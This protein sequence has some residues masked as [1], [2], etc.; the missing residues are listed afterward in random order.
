M[1]H[2]ANGVAV[3]AANTFRLCVI[4]WRNSTPTLTSNRAAKLR[5][6]VKAVCKFAAQCTHVVKGQ[7]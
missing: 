4:S 6:Q 7:S 1:K 2:D 5:L 3:V